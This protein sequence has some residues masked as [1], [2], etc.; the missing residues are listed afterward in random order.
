MN[1]A[2]AVVY[3]Y[4]MVFLI[5]GQPVTAALYN[6][7]AISTSKPKMPTADKTARLIIRNLSF[8]VYV[9]IFSLVNLICRCIYTCCFV[10]VVIGT[11]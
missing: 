10:A 7:A 3:N 2:T 8:K 9:Q 4:V 1:Y 5:S 6:H 11:V